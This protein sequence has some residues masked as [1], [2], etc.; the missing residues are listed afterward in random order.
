MSSPF[1][2][3]GGCQRELCRVGDNP[4]I[5]RHRWLCSRHGIGS[6]KEAQVLSSDRRDRLRMP[7]SI[8]DAP[9]QLSGEV[10]I[11]AGAVTLE[12]ELQMPPKARSVILFVH[13]SGSSRHSP[14]NQSVARF[15]QGKGLG[16]LL[17]DLLTR[18]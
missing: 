2:F 9:S 17:F 10:R 8:T 12:G 7:Y 4:M 18:E 14:R 1:T 6:G 3:P 11:P 5:I 13:G 15:L 16:T